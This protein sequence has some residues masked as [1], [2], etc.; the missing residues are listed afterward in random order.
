MAQKRK[1][2]ASNRRKPRIQSEKYS[3][4]ALH[5]DRE[6][7]MYWYAWLWKLLRPVLIF[8]CSVLVVVGMVSVGY[9]RIYGAFFAPVAADS[10]STV[11]FQIE[12]GETVSRIG[13]RLEEANLLRDQ[14]VFRY[15]VQFRGLTNAL[16]Y[17]T[18]KL[19]PGMSVDQIIDELTS[20]SQTNERVITIVPGWTCDDIAEYLVSVGALENT[21]EFLKLC[22]DVDRFVG[23]SYALRDAQNNGRLAGRK[24]ALE[25]YLAPDTYRIFLTASPESIIRTLLN[26]DNKV[27]DDVFY[28]DRTEYYADEEGVYHEVE[29]YDNTLGMD[30]IV[31]LASM[32]EKEAGNR[33]D[34]GRVSAVFHNRLKLG[35]KLE[36]DPTA[37]Y[38]SRQHK[39]ALTE[40]ETSQQ[41]G[42]NTYYVPALPVG[43]ICNPS[44]A[45]LEAA[46]SPDMDYIEQ[47]YL[48]FCATEPTSGTLAFAITQEEHDA[49]VARYRPLWEEYDRQQALQQQEAAQTAQP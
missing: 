26:Q 30:E 34:Y 17:G 13:A 12:N 45:A 8:L 29:T 1:R 48:Y 23:N 42:Y 24:Y 2:R 33:E 39:L 14:R 38:L 49:N 28:T 16:S 35:W 20:D 10:A 18:F 40:A 41:N 32:I 46:M 5:E 37:T 22:N 31:T 27:I 25:G 36:S 11:A 9:N 21:Q 4:R 44:V 7:G 3:I 6:Y 15:M 47:G 19:S 43:P